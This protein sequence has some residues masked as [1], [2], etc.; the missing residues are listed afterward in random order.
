MEVNKK[1]GGSIHPF[2]VCACGFKYVVVVGEGW[3]FQAVQTMLHF[4]TR[5]CITYITQ[6]LYRVDSY[7]VY[8]KRTAS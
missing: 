2:I 1:E 5:L 3:K 6:K 4:H 7:P 8:V